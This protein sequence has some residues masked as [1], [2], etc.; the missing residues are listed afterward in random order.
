M[1]SREPVTPAVRHLR[2][3]GVEY[4]GHAYDYERFEGAVGAARALGIEPHHAVKTIV[5][6]TS[7]GDGVLALMNGDLEI[8]TKT[9]ARLLGVKSVEPAGQRESRRWT[10]YEFG[11]TSPFGTRTELPL[12]AHREIDGMEEIYINGGRRGFLVKIKTEDL[13]RLL[14]PRFADLS[15]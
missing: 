3:K 15:T 7:E 10:G 14:D 13:R 2:A 4:E 12:Y 8:S 1:R 5:F 9:L 11:G 6:E